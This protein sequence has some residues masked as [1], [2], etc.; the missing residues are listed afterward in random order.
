MK[1]YDFYT[2]N[3]TQALNILEHHTQY[4]RTIEEGGESL[5]NIEERGFL[6]FFRGSWKIDEDQPFGSSDF[7]TYPNRWGHILTP[8]FVHPAFIPIIANLLEVTKQEIYQIARFEAY[9]E[10]TKIVGSADALETTSTG[11]IAILKKLKR[12]KKNPFAERPH[13]KAKDLILSKLPIP[14][15][16]ERP[17]IATVGK[18]QTF[19]LDTILINDFFIY[20]D[21]ILSL[22]QQAYKIQS[23]EIQK[24]HQKLQKI[25]EQLIYVIE[26]GIKDDYWGLEE[27]FRTSIE[28]MR[29][30]ESFVSIKPK[31]AKLSKV[32]PPPYRDEKPDESLKEIPIACLW[33]K[34]REIWLQFIDRLVGIDLDKNKVIQEFS[35]PNL[36]MLYFDKNYEQILFFGT[37]DLRHFYSSDFWHLNT[38]SGKWHTGFQD[39]FRYVELGEL[40]YEAKIW[41]NYHRQLVVPLTYLGDYPITNILS[42]DGAYAWIQDKHGGGGIFELATGFCVTDIDTLHSPLT[43]QLYEN[44]PKQSI[45]QTLP[46]HFVKMMESENLK[47]KSKLASESFGLAF[48][49][50]VQTDKQWLTYHQGY[51]LKDDKP[52]LE[53]DHIFTSAAF[54]RSGG[55]MLLANPGFICIID[56]EQLELGESYLQCVDLQ[57]IQG[58]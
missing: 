27:K 19:A 56:I 46:T 16:E 23:N 8:P 58:K 38:S 57:N 2:T 11:P 17:Q 30:R 47:E 50:L 39:S 5:G 9:W 45:L 36:R 1:I 37:N 12:V 52:I 33:G 32:F 18:H 25:L 4:T 26:T 21:Y 28:K 40:V 7:Q 54:H 3:P 55:Y 31:D 43:M 42:P 22:T 51:L 10:D 29:D 13:I 41:V 53:T 49:A 35:C 44:P 20:S 14:P 34:N 15:Y 48:G 6:W 24:Y